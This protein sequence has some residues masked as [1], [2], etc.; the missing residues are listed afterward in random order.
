MPLAFLCKEG[1]ECSNNK[2]VLGSSG[3]PLGPCS[4]RYTPTHTGFC[5]RLIFA[6]I[7][8]PSFTAGWGEVIASLMP[9]RAGP[10]RSREEAL[11]SK[12]CFHQFIG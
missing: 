2:L 8:G 5:L 7:V 3:P 6:Y 4:V 11:R 9:A 12:L 10:C 1:C